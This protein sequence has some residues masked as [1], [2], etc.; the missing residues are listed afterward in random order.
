MFSSL[1]LSDG[2]MTVQEL[3]TRGLAPPGSSSP[4]ASQAAGQLRRNEVLGFVSALL[5]RG[6]AGILASA[7]A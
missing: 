4:H 6:T 5:T 1:V 3:Y 2:P 7:A